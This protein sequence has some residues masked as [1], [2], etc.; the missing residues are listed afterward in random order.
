MAK[1][2]NWQKQRIML[3]LSYKRINHEWVDIAKTFK[4]AIHEWGSIAEEELT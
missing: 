4:K 2:G 3:L 1:S